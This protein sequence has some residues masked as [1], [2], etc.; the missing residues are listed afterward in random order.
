[1]RTYAD[2]FT[3]I[4]QIVQDTGNAIYDTTEL[5]Y[6]IEEGLK[7]FATYRPHEV[8]TT[9]TIESRTGTATSTS[10]NNLVDTKGQFVTGDAANEKVVWNSRQ[11]T[12]AVVETFTSAT[13]LGLSADIFTSGDS[14]RIYNKRCRN[15]RQIYI[16][17][18]EFLSIER[19]EYPINRRPEWWRN[20][21]LLHGDTVLEVL[22]N[23][24]DD[25]NPTL[26]GNSVEVDVHF[27]KPHILNQMTDLSGEITANGTA[28]ATSIGIDGMGDTE[29]IE[30]G[31]EFYFENHRTLYTITQDVTT[32][33]NAA[34]IKFFP[35]LEAALTEDDNIT[36]TRST[37]HAQDEVLFAEMVAGKAV[38]SDARRY[39]NKVETGGPGVWRD[40]FLWGQTMYE[41]SIRKANKNVMK[42]RQRYSQQGVGLFR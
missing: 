1:M 9:F 2:M 15:S 17:D 31:S 10:S 3:L 33:A 37:L 18:A 26:T 29:I 40:F 38:M 28:G 25:S 35:G 21:R 8:I 27:T 13:T 11:K 32:S 20:W 34:T 41:G 14:Y 39:M 6:G 12:W 5:G 23:S 7:E 22:V 19:V 24:V 30:E 16:G 4:S 36:F 42:T